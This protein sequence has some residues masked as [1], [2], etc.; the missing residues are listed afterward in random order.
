MQVCSVTFAQQR[1]FYSALIHFESHLN[2]V[3]RKTKQFSTSDMRLR[4]ITEVIIVNF[5][6]SGP[7]PSQTKNMACFKVKENTLLAFKLIKI[8]DCH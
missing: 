6:T 2:L 3:L 4:R 7:F 1:R 5:W 8:K